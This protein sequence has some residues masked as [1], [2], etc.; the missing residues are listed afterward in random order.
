M[1]CIRMSECLDTLSIYIK[2]SGNANINSRNQYKHLWA[3]TSLFA[4]KRCSSTTRN[5][6]DNFHCDCEIKLSMK[7]K[8]TQ[9]LM[10]FLFG[11]P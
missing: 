2:F 5:F 9:L 11:K 6:H 4:D 7:V 3:M 10:I 8:M 1:E